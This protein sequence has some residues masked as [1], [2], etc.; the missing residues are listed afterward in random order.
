MEAAVSLA[1]ASPLKFK[2]KSLKKMLV[3][4]LFFGFGA[5][6]FGTQA[7]FGLAEFPHD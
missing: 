3:E 6:D 4:L 5:A 2:E 7:V 1:S